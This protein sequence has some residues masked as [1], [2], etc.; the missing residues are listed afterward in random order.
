MKRT[1]VVKACIVSGLLI[2]AAGAAWAQRP[3]GPAGRPAPAGAPSAAGD[4]TRDLPSVQR[5][6]T[7]LKGD[8]EADTLARQV[9]VLVY[10]PYYVDRIRVARGYNAQYTPAETQLIKDAYAA[11]TQMQADFKKSH[12]AAEFDAWYR[13]EQRYEVMNAL[14]W[15]TQLAGQGAKDTYRGAEVSLAQSYQRHE[16]DLQRQF[17]QAQNGPSRG[18]AGDPVL[19]PLGIFAKGEADRVKDPELRRCLELGSSLQ[20][21]EGANML[22]GFGTLLFGGFLQPAKK[23]QPNPASEVAGIVYA[24]AFQGRPG[25]ASLRLE[26][27]VNG[28]GGVIVGCGKL[29]DTIYDAHPYTVRRGPGGQI[30]L[31]MANGPGPIALAVQPDGGLLGPGLV[32]VQGRV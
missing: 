7:E 24:G 28:G 19:D 15:I 26:T 20:A 9:S 23:E 21:C 30:Q 5:I 8:N 3:P 6:R 27:A 13:T 14:Q 25:Q 11:Q 12:S 1:A 2:G 22:E 17:Q 29:V 4:Y 18:I 32:A 31:I 10:L 16:E